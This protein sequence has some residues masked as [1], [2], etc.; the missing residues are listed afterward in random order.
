MVSSSIE[1]ACNRRYWQVAQAQESGSREQEADAGGIAGDGYFNG[2]DGEN[3]MTT[4][5]NE[6]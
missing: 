3:A 6:M 2:G 1:W 5:R 4:I